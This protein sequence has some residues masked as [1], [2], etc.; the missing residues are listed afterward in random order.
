MQ[1]EL[2][3][4]VKLLSIQ[5]NFLLELKHFTICFV[6]YLK[7]QKISLKEVKEEANKLI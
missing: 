1:Q 2:G 5:R 7:E 4:V 3:H 6:F